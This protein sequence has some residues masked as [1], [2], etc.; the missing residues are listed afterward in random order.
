MS[1]SLDDE[2]GDKI[3]FIHIKDLPSYVKILENNDIV[4]YSKDT[5]RFLNKKIK[6]LAILSAFFIQVIQWI[7]KK[8]LPKAL[9]NK[10]S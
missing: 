7:L 3:F 4:I 1:L 6:H 9:K 8:K 10:H 5:H 2:D